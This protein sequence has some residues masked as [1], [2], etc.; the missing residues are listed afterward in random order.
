MILLEPGNRVLTETVSALFKISDPTAKRDPIDVRLCDFDEV[1]YR[2]T[3]DPNARNIMT[4]SISLPCWNEIKDMGGIEL[5]NTTYAGLS[6]DAVSGYDVTLKFDFENLPA[7]ADELI[8][9]VNYLKANL[10]G[11]VFQ[12][13]LSNL[14]KGGAAAEPFKF[15]MRPDTHIYF[16]P[17]ADRVTTIFSLDFTERVDR[18]VAKVFLQEFE[19]TRR[20]LGAAPPCAF[21]VNPPLEMKHFGIT[22]PQGNQLGYLSFALLKNHVDNNKLDRA[23]MTLQTFRNYLQYHIKC[24][25]TFF[26]ARMRARVVSLL[27]LLNRAKQEQED[28]PKRLLSGKYFVRKE[29]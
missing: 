4:V 21:T 22:E 20:H 6:T 11:S 2:V 5:L 25:K 17:G 23:V 24:S 19:D 13:F 16:F 18:A 12:R 29:G 8:K 15:S 10:L 26:H 9:K 28:Q 7:P 3:V 1:Q 14:L 27:K